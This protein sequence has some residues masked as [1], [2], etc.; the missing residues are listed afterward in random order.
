M[1]VRSGSVVVVDPPCRDSEVDQIPVVALKAADPCAWA[2]Q[3]PSG[4]EQLEVVTRVDLRSL[5]SLEECSVVRQQTVDA[6]CLS[7]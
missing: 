3:H 2:V 6:V 1:E 7:V 4:V 5:D